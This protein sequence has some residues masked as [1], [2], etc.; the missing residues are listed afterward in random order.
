VTALVDAYARLHER[1][2]IHSDVHPSNVL[3]DAAGGI[4]I[5]DFGYARF[6]EP[7]HPLSIAPR[8]GAGLFFE[9]ECAQAI[10]AGRQGPLS[11][12]AGEQYSVAAIA[13]EVLTGSPHLDF[14][15]KFDE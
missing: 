9:P 5:L 14:S 7:E 12:T 3:A 10:V 1:G 13:F 2:V 8:A 4:T 11:S 15:P 6:S